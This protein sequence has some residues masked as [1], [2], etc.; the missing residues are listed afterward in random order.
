MTTVSF[1]H[2]ERITGY[3]EVA[4]RLLAVVAGRMERPLRTKREFP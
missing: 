1:E 2:S 4:T 3:P